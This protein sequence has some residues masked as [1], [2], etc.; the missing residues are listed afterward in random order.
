MPLLALWGCGD[1]ED[2]DMGQLPLKGELQEFIPPI[3]SGHQLTYNGVSSPVQYEVY[4]GPD[5]ELVQGKLTG[6]KELRGKLLKYECSEY[7]TIETEYFKTYIDSKDFELNVEVV[8]SKN[9]D[10]V[11]NNSFN[12]V[13]DVDDVLKFSLGYSN[14]FPETIKVQNQSYS[15]YTPVRTFIFSLHPERTIVASGA[16]K[17]ANRIV[18]EYLPSLTINGVTHEGVYHLYLES[19]QFTGIEHELY[20]LYPFT[21]VQGIYVKSGAGLLR[22]YTSAGENIDFH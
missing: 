18:Q 1:C 7:Y 8:H 16:H 15:S 17:F 3:V 9:V 19:P 11:D 21:Y 13:E 14:S 2:M 12:R 22:V 6:D 5:D 10:P 20:E 4:N